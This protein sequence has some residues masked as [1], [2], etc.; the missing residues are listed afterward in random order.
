MMKGLQMRK[1]ASLLA[2]VALTI[3]VL[4]T[5]AAPASAS[6]ATTGKIS[7]QPA[8]P[9]ASV[10]YKVNNLKCFSN[11]IRFTAKQQENGFSGVT[12][13][14]Q[15]VREQEFTNRGWVNITGTA[16]VTSNRFPNDG[17]SFFFTR[18]WT[19]THAANGASYR[20]LWQGLYFSGSRVAFR[21][22]VI[23]ATCA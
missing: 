20:S 19:S 16:A 6:T 21:T 1:F 12:Q 10:T 9:A 4:A 11:A 18:V 2:T 14:R 17:R 5:A 8:M 23:T 3:G 13:F 22:P 7:A 15:L